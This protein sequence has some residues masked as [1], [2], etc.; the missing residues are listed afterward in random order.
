MR[1]LEIEKE[2][3]TT[4]G[5]M[6]MLMLMLM[7]TKTKTIRQARGATDLC[8]GRRRREGRVAG[9]VHTEHA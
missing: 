5:L 4:Q 1:G 2:M 6:L 3:W 8:P 9:A 7:K